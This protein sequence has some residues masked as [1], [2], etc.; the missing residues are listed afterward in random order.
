MS[1]FIKLNPYEE[2][3][4]TFDDF[5]NANF[6]TISDLMLRDDPTFNGKIR[7]MAISNP[8]IVDG[9]YIGMFNVHVLNNKYN[10]SNLI[11][12]RFD[13]G[14]NVNDS[15]LSS[16]VEAFGTTFGDERD[17]L[18]IRLSLVQFESKALAH[19]PIRFSIVYNTYSND[20]DIIKN[21]IRT[22]QTTSHMWEDPA[23]VLATRL[24]FKDAKTNINGWT[25]TKADITAQTLWVK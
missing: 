18:E 24:F 25:P 4:K 13:S 17:I 22:K 5:F 7:E 16:N 20:T 2:I 8:V 14:L 9:R 6:N 23:M 21:A 3:T 1:K 12:N 15:L 11:T 10:V 19:A